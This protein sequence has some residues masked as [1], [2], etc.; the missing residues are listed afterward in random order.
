MALDGGIYTHIPS[1]RV[2]LWRYI[3]QLHGSAM[4]VHLISAEFKRDA[5]LYIDVEISRR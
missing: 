4:L 5:I 2:V 3:G 1:N